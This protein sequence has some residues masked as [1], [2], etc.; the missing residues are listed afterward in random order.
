M[1]AKKVHTPLACSSVKCSMR[2]WHAA[3]ACSTGM[4]RKC[5]GPS[6]S[7]ILAKVHTRWRQGRALLHTTDIGPLR[8]TMSFKSGGKPRASSHVAVHWK[9]WLEKACC[10]VTNLPSQVRRPSN[11]T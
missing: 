1:E 2:H 4:Q 11:Q 5:Q 6:P 8:S 10:C 3:L 7:G 9:G